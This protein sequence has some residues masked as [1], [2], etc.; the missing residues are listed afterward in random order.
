METLSDDVKRQRLL[1]LRSSTGVPF[2][3]CRRALEA[4]GY[5][6]SKAMN[7]LIAWSRESKKRFGGIMDG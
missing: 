1:E 6:T 2:L 4:T 3:E 5:D 7:L